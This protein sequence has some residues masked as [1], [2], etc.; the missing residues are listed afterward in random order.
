MR[1]LFVS[2]LHLDSS[3]PATIEAFSRFLEGE[4]RGATSLHILGDLFEIWIGDDDP[5]PVCN[6]VCVALRALSD[7]GVAVYVMQGNRDFLY[8]EAFERRIG[9]TLISDP[10]VVTLV[11][12]RVLLTHGDLMCTGDTAYQ[13]LRTIVRDPRFR[14][15]VLKL[16]M[17]ARQI[18]ANATRA[19]SKVHTRATAATIMD[20]TPSAVIA[21]LEASGTRKMIHGHTHRPAEHRHITRDGNAERVVLSAWDEAGEYL[22]VTADG[23]QRRKIA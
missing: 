4:A 6:R 13:E 8:G 22:E 23:W 19:G 18:L 17:D 1:H 16:P 21:A 14:D 3:T 15:R 12:E 2:D 7:A 9:G 5:N 10:S 20:V 11:G